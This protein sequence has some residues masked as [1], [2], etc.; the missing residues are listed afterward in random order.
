MKN[1]SAESRVF[2]NT[3][4]NKA[5]NRDP[6]YPVIIGYAV[7]MNLPLVLDTEVSG[8][9]AYNELDSNAI[10]YLIDDLNSIIPF[11][12]MAAEESTKQFFLWRQA[13]A[14]GE[15]KYQVRYVKD[16]FTRTS[17]FIA[18]DYRDLLK[19]YPSS[20]YIQRAMNGVVNLIKET[21]A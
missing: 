13:I 12:T 11:D 6:L 18:K 4:L 20:D 17:T 2:V 14:R 21:K 3:V 16:L 10:I 15:L 9:D 5:F 1:I 19:G 7:A 8:I